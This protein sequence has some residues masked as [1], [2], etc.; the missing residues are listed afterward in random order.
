MAFAVLAE[1]DRSPGRRQP[2]Y[3]S[4][5]PTATI[6]FVNRPL[7][8]LLTDGTE[9]GPISYMQGGTTTRDD[10][11]AG[12]TRCSR[13][14]VVMPLLFQPELSQSPCPVHVDHVRQAVK[15]GHRRITAGNGYLQLGSEV[16]VTP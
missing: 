3:Q 9:H 12:R 13:Q 4:R 6:R 1:T 10:G 2:V 15:D 16:C 5:R 7:E 8:R 14:W 11:S